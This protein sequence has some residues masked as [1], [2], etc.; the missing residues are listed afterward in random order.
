MFKVNSYFDGKVTSLGF[1]SAEG[2]ATSGVIAPG[3]YEFNTGRRERMEITSG[4]ADVLLK[5]EHFWTSYPAG[6]HFHVPEGS[7]FKIRVAA[8]TTY[9]C[10][11]G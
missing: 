6:T 1:T 5:G 11:F 10:Y 4:A 2:D 3:E 9:L 8:D 7:S